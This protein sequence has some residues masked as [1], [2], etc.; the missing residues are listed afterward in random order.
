M[1]QSERYIRGLDRNVEGNL[2]EGAGIVF[3][4]MIVH[5]VGGCEPVLPDNWD[6]ATTIYHTTAKPK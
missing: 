5:L 6:T 1:N 3:V 4:I 2:V